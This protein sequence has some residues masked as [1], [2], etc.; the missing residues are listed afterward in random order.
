MTVSL[1]SDLWRGVSL[2][3]DRQAHTL[4]RKS[5]IDL[6]LGLGKMC[7]NKFQLCIWHCLHVFYSML[8]KMGNYTQKMLTTVQTNT[9]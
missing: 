7:S 2:I 1:L 5:L 8:V 3:L 9:V 4:S 6:L